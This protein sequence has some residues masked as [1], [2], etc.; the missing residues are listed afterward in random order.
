MHTKKRKKIKTKD[1]LKPTGPSMFRRN[2][3]YKT[4]CTVHNAH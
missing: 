2:W 4:E 1:K 3:S